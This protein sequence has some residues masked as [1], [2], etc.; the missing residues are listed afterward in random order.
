MRSTVGPVGLLVLQSTGFCN[1][2]CVYCYLPDR[3]NSR[4]TM[5]LA[6]VAQVA[7]L[8]GDGSLLD[9]HLDIVWHAGE[10]LVLPPSY[11]AEAIDILEKARPPRTTFHYGVQT[12]ATLINNAWIDFFAEHDVKVGI[13]LDGPRDLHDRNRKA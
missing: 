10:P 4:Q 8:I 6:T 11:Y 12:N 13:S 9:D 5:P 3:N 2:D 7:R 1:I